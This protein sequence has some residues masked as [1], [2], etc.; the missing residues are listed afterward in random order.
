MSEEALKRLRW[1]VGSTLAVYF[2][3]CFWIEGGI[4]PVAIILGIVA[5]FYV[6][7][8]LTEW[9]GENTTTGIGLII[10]IILINAFMYLRGA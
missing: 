10:M 1:I 6:F 7:C 4:I 9:L 3:S 2:L 8:C 5:S